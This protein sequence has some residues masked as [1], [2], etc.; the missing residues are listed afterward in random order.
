MNKLTM[1]W[2]DESRRIKHSSRLMHPLKFAAILASSLALAASAQTDQQP[3]A[4]TPPPPATAVTNAPVATATS[5]KPR[6]ARTLSLQDCIE[7]A[8]AHN[9]DI[10]I[11]RFNPLIDQY[12]LQAVYSAY[13]PTMTLTAQKSYNG[14]PGSLVVT[15]NGTFIGAG[16]ERES[17]AYTPELKGLLPTGLTYELNGTWS[18]N[19]IRSAGQTSWEQPTWSANPGITLDQPLLKNFWI[20][21]TR[22]QIRLNK[23]AV[24]ISEQ[25]L[26]LQIM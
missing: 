18:R 15:T 5:D 6:T 13:D 17:D 11:Q 23:A 9:F 3:P 19:S 24:K 8:L 14:S 22:L 7:L 16:T 10:Q 4:T 1:R 21:N 20:D 12:A 2:F 26:R 25:V